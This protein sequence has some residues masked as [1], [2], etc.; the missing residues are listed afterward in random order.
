MSTNKKKIQER[1]I[2]AS[3]SS[4]G[5]FSLAKYGVVVKAPIKWT[6][7]QAVE[8]L[9][10]LHLRTDIYLANLT[11]VIRETFPECTVEAIRDE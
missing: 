10:K 6:D 11:K 9:E 2:I 3:L 8:A 5:T 4:E 1:V 7:A